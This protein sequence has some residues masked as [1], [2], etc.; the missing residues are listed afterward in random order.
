MSTK[1]NIP[2]AR[3]ETPD[4]LVL[5]RERL[6]RRLL[7][8][9][10][11]R[12]QRRWRRTVVA[13]CVAALPLFFVA[14]SHQSRLISED[15]DLE[16]I[17]TVDQT[18]HSATLVMED[19][20]G[21]DHHWNVREGDDPAAV[22]QL[23]ERTREANLAGETEVVRL[24]GFTMDGTTVFMSHRRM[25]DEEGDVAGFAVDESAWDRIPDRMSMFVAEWGE[26]TPDEA[27]VEDSW[28]LPGESRLVD[29]EMR[30]FARIAYRTSRWGLVVIWRWPADS[31]P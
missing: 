20:R 29:G 27:G 26:V 31:L 10:E 25:S 14:D 11:R 13:C 5:H 23:A 8:R 24:E 6:K 4:E 16:P 18:S 22:R 9:F 1:L 7:N 28:P 15:F 17:G 2:V 12:A 21:G 3:P 30:E 19:A